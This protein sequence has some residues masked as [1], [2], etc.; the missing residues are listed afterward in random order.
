MLGLQR[1]VRTCKASFPTQPEPLSEVYCHGCLKEAKVK[2]FR[3]S[4][5]D[6]PA[7]EK[8]RLKHFRNHILGEPNESPGLEVNR[9]NIFAIGSTYFVDIW[10]YLASY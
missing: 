6:C 10:E 3:H 5:L 7:F 2:K 9:L 8:L 1:L 4:L